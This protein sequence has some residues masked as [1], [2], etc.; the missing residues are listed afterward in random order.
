[1]Q[2]H[3]VRLLQ[4]QQQV[5][6]FL[7][8]VL[9][10]DKAH[11]KNKIEYDVITAEKGIVDGLNEPTLTSKEYRDIRYSTEK[12]RLAL[13]NQI[14][15]ELFKIDQLG[16]DDDIALGKG[17][18]KPATTKATQDAYILTGL[19]ASGKSSIATKIA[20]E[21]GAYILD[22]DFAK[23]KL[24]EYD[25]FPW[26][27]SIVHSESKN[28]VFGP[29]SNSFQSLFSIV[30]NSKQN[31]II[32]TIG[33]EPIDVIGQGKLLK[34]LGYKV[35][36]TLI[37]LSKEKAT[38][39]ALKRFNDTNRYVPLSLIF[40]V[41]S[42]NPALTYFLLRTK[43]LEIFTSFGVINTDVPQG[44]EPVCTDFLGKNPAKNL[45]KIDTKSLI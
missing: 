32:P 3:F 15:D 26:G 2:N 33:G 23:R 31:L 11:Y 35:H 25:G 44:E 42:E 13:R 14:V 17:G 38:L 27:A 22:A 45:Y 9:N 40:D 1:M 6:H 20:N 8:T 28:I 7:Y 39:R 36:L 10:I 43:A 5:N 30:M 16:N 4:N 37:H 19:P 34:Q 18:A 24:P 41:Y 29:D 12:A 21:Y